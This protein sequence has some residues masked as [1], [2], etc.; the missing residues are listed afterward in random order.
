MRDDQ[1]ESGRFRRHSIVIGRER[2][3]TMMNGR[4]IE[5][6]ARLNREEIG[7]QIARNRLAA[8]AQVRG[9]S[10]ALRRRLAIVLVAVAARLAPTAAPAVEGEA[11][12]GILGS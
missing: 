10:G 9:N 6:M 3:G 1:R 2:Q 7:R 12:I 4:E 8:S 11:R 5:L